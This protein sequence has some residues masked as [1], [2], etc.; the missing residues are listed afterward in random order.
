MAVIS[1]DAKKQLRKPLGK[2]Y[3]DASFL[4]NMRKR[5]I[6]VGDEST[7]NVLRLGIV[8][9]LAVFDF[10]VMRKK[11]SAA[12]KRMLLSSFTS[13]RKYRNRKGTLS[14]RILR[15]AKRLLREGGAVLIDGEEDLTALAFILAGGKK[16]LV[17]YGQPKTGMVAVK[18]EKVKK[19]IKKMLGLAP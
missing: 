8:P 17:V 14:G 12:K 6:S 13:V 9:H 11:I 1:D 19:K 10:R 16:D 7:A 4:K 2:V 15:D 18:P 5:I 3:P